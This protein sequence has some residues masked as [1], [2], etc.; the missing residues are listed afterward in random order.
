ML[1]FQLHIVIWHHNDKTIMF[2]LTLTHVA[3]YQGRACSTAIITRARGTH[4]I[5]F[6]YNL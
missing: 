2:I 1:V 5:L 3:K 4:N 6:S